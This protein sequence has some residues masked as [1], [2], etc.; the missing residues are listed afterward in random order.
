[1]RPD[2]EKKIASTFAELG[3]LVDSRAE[4]RRQEHQKKM[5]FETSETSRDMS[6]KNRLE[7]RK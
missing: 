6:R 1:M 7:E 5:A 3:C 2:K 4:N